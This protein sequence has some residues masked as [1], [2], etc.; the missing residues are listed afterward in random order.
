MDKGDYVNKPSENSSKHTQ[1]PGN[2]NQDRLKTKQQSVFAAEGSYQMSPSA[3][4]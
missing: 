4:S 3:L 2:K 1:R